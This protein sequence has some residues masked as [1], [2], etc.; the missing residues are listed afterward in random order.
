[1]TVA[2]FADS[3]ENEFLRDAL[4][5][6]IDL[7]E[8]PVIALMRTLAWM[9]QRAAGY[10]VGGSKAL[11]E[12]LTTRYRALGGE[13]EYGARVV[14]ILVE[15]DAA[16]GVRL[17]DGRAIHGDVVISAADGH[18]TLFDWL[19]GRY[20]GPQLRAAYDSMP[21]FPPL[22]H[23]ALGVNKELPALAPAV[24]GFDF[25][26]EEP[27]SIDHQRCPRLQAQV[28]SFDPTLAPAGKQVIKV[29]LPSNY[30]RWRVLSENRDAYE[31]AKSEAAAQVVA[32]LEQRFPGLSEGV[33][34]VDVATPMTW[35]RYTGN[36]QGSYEG[37]LLTP[38]TWGRRLPREVPGLRQFYMAG[39][40]VEPGGG[41][42]T[43]A[44]SGRNVVRSICR[45]Q[46]QRFVTSVPD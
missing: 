37:W 13:V 41:L 28:Y 17:A 33:E 12:A 21:V 3:F 38:S 39:Q 9:D 30:E 11:V 1:V 19:G 32:A 42:R 40:W 10:P 43:A 31:K 8:F 24:M 36:W 23:V 22:L 45:A 18:G 7:P 20:L 25:P 46:R 34:I 15:N 16:V 27:V 2:E 29:M 35:E 6:V 44:R 5:R 26:L 14:E 4:A